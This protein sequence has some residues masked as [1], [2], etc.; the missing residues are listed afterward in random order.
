MFLKL[1]VINSSCKI[2]L[3]TWFLTQLSYKQWTFIDLISNVLLSTWKNYAKVVNFFSYF[4][5]LILM[6]KVPNILANKWR[7]FDNFYWMF[8]QFNFYAGRK[9]GWT[10]LCFSTYFG[11]KS[12][13]FDFLYHFF[14]ILD[15]FWQ[16][17]F[18]SIYTR[19]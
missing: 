15:I 9:I 7:N 13:L 8:F 2:I 1:V 6:L 10:N 3:A 12:S 18:N 11:S 5:F 16:F 4:L 14:E 19:V 17:F